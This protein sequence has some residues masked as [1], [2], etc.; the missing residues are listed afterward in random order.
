MKLTADAQSQLSYYVEAIVPGNITAALCTDIVGGPAASVNC[1]TT[2]CTGDDSVT[3]DCDAIA[4]P[5]DLTISDSTCIHLNV[6]TFKILA[7]APSFANQSA[8]PHSI[9][10]PAL[11]FS[12][13][14]S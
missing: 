13:D 2:Q 5:P 7:E 6:F 3:S 14:L 8:M 11:V 10:C 1:N 4:R 12:V 9:P